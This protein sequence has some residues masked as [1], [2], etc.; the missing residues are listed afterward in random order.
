MLYLPKDGAKRWSKFEVGGQKFYDETS[1]F[2]L[3]P[4]SPPVF[5]FGRDF[6]NGHSGLGLAAKMVQTTGLDL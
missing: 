5:R 6:F 4:P 1:N 3:F 2:E